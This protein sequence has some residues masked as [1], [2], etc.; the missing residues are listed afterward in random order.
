M[1]LVSTLTVVALLMAVP[2]LL[3][4]AENGATLYESNCAMCHGEKGEGNADMQMPA[5]AGTAMTAEQ[6]VTYLLKG[7]KNKTVHAEP[8]AGLNDEQGKVVSE[9]VITL[10]K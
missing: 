1:K 7:D 9:F 2:F 10:K 4:A 3:W 8:I 5:V 6:M